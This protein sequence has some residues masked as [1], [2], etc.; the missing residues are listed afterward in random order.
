MGFGWLGAI[1][2]ARWISSLLYGVTPFDVTTFA[3][4]SVLLAV[5]ALLSSFIPARRAAKAD[6]MSSLRYE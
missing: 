3:S 1:L 5:V 2:L 6:P 4:V